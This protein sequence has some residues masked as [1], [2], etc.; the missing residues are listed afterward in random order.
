[1]EEKKFDFN[2]IIG[3]VLL[4]AIMLWWMYTTQPTPEEIAAEEKAKSEQIQ[5]EIEITK[6]AEYSPTETVVKTTDSTSFVSRSIILT[7]LF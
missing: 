4:G 5:K 2:S 6:A 7:L 1:M 3:F